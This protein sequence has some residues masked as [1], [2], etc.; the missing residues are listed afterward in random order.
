[1][2]SEQ[3]TVLPDLQEEFYTDIE[4]DSDNSVCEG[5]QSTSSIV[6]DSH[7]S[8]N[9]GEHRSMLTSSL[10]IPYSQASVKKERE[11]QLYKEQV[12]FYDDAT[13]KMYHRIQ[14]ARNKS[15]HLKERSRSFGCSEQSSRKDN[16]K[17]T[18]PHGSMFP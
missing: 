17:P 14:S 13:W 8:T 11:D 12:Y 1:M 2:N 16:T 6:P 7:I 18:L 9:S 15:R 3:E 10:P 4:H 5:H